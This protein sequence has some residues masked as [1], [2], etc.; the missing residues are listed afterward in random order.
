MLP[1][2]VRGFLSGEQDGRHL[3]YDA[4]FP[5]RA[6]I[7]EEFGRRASEQ[8]FRADVDGEVVVDLVV[9]ALLNQL[10]ATGSGPSETFA[11]GVVDIVLAGVRRRT[12]GTTTA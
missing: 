6:R 5:N 2:L 10:L 11:R 9:G 7:V 1:V 4:L 3:T 8:G 12:T